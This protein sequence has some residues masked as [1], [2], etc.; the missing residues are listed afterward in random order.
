MAAAAEAAA[1]EV[2]FVVAHY[3][4]DVGKLLDRL[5]A[6]R[7]DARA[8]VYSKGPSPPPGAHVLPNV[9]REAH[10]FLHHIV[11]RYDSLAGVTV[12]LQA[13]AL[14]EDAGANAAMK[15]AG[16]DNLLRC[17][18]CLRRLREDPARD[19]A[20][21]LPD[22][23]F[24]PNFVLPAWKGATDEHEKALAPASPRPLRAWYE[25]HV[26][27]PFPPPFWCVASQFAASARLL[28]ARPRDFYA[29]LL[30]QLAAAGPDAEAAHFMERSWAGAFGA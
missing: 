23:G 9:G 6:E 22:P 24:D 15:R 20:C 17:L 27:R 18:R 4:E 29:R 14:G 12:F 28:R 21:G 1:P 26:G 10:T 5:R 13:S 11:E 19:F 3:T 8:T 2:E 30:A 16:L 25:A 7:P